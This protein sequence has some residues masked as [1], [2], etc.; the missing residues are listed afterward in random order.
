[1]TL[2]F[3]SA[4]TINLPGILTLHQENLAQNHSLEKIQK[5][6][7]GTVVHSLHNLKKIC[8]PY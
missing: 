4:K 7:F 3:T 5:E 6:G 2:Q 8:S 1:M